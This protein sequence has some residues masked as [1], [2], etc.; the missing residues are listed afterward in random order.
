MVWFTLGFRLGYLPLTAPDEGRNAEVAREMK[1]SGAWLVPTYNGVDYLD[2][3]AFYFK[4]VALSLSAFGDNETAARLPSAL[5]AAALVAAVCV[6]C[7]KVY[8]P[9]CGWLAAIVVS[10]MPLFLMN[11]RTVIFDMALALFVCG[12][13][14]AGWLAEEAEGKARRNWYLLGAAAA[15]LATLVKGPVGFLIP[16][17]VLLVFNRVEGRPGAWKRLLAPMNLLVFFAVTLPWFVGLCLVHPDFLHY[18][19]VEES[20]HR[21]TTSSGF[22]RSEPF[23]FYLLI[24]AGTFFPWSLL[25]PE[26]ALATWRGHLAKNRA[27]R[28]CLVWS[29][30]VVVFFSISQSKLPGYILSVTVSAGILAAR[31]FDVALAEPDGRVSRLAGR[32]T[33]ALA[34]VSLLLAAGMAVLAAKSEMRL[35]ARPMR[36]PV[37]DA[38]RVGRAMTP[39]LAVLAGFGIFGLVA[40]WRRNAM[41][42]FL[43]FAL[44]VPLAANA[45]MGVIDVI[46][47][48]KS[49]RPTARAL[50]ALPPGTELACLQCFPNGLAF[51]LGRTVTLFTQNGGEIT[52]ESNYIKYLLT[53]DA[54][55]PAPIRPLADFDT[56]LAAQKNPVC[57]IVR[58]S[59][60][61]R[62]QTIAAGRGATI[63]P[64]AADYWGARLPAPGIP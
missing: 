55:W 26:A 42:S 27:D 49:G 46:V 45:G 3:P 43:C 18:G 35:L 30:V 31:L 44:F 8:G 17:L 2:K 24:V 37:A 57:L 56:W 29:V 20:F 14:F 48:A 16:M 13:I 64:L 22:H 9:R 12:A 1:L 50:A 23:Y 15:G 40:R 7:R 5:F 58:Q 36:I 59:N 60:T 25:L 51:Y 47:N 61:N 52:S 62:L 54:P 34:I 21:F 19:L 4:A 53:R 28:L 41:L 11:A 33:V 63:Q 38:E 6:F 10:T 39:L 32:A